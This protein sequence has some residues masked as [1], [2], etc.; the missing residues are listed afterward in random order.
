M[1]DTLIRV[2]NVIG[3]IHFQRIS[4]WRNICFLLMLLAIVLPC[5]A[6]GGCGV[7]EGNSSLRYSPDSNIL[8]FAYGDKAR[9]VR[10]LDLKTGGIIKTFPVEQSVSDLAFSPDGELLAA[11]ILLSNEPCEEIGRAHV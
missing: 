11:S 5:N 9:P 2:M 8:A 1:T 7:R 3:R 10:L 6:S 4:L